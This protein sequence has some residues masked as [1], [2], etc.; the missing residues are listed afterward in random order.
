MTADEEGPEP[1]LLR[2][3]ERWYRRALE[4]IEKF[5]GPCQVDRV[6]SYST[7][8]AILEAVLKEVERR[9]AI[10]PKTRF[11]QKI[12]QELRKYSEALAA[13]MKAAQRRYDATSPRPWPFGAKGGL[14]EEWMR[15]AEEEDE[16]RPPA[17]RGLSLKGR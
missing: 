5:T 16:A 2:L 13:A 11:Q 6:V 9:E 10:R 3:Q 1:W 12:L 7:V 8:S 14:N 4:D 15:L 17:T